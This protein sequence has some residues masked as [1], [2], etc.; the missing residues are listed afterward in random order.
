MFACDFLDALRSLRIGPRRA[1]HIA[2][3]LSLGFAFAEQGPALASGHGTDARR[4]LMAAMQ[5]TRYERR[6][7]DRAGRFSGR[8]ILEVGRV[9]DDPQEPGSVI[10]TM[11]VQSYDDEGRLKS[12]GQV[13]WRC[14][15]A[16][17]GMVMSL[18]IF[19]GEARK[20][21]VR[22]EAQGEPIMYPSTPRREEKLEDIAIDLKVKKGILP[23]L[24][25]R[26]A[27]LFANRRIQMIASPQNGKTPRQ[28]RITGDLVFKSYALGIRFNTKELRSEELIDERK[29]LIEQVL[30][31]EDGSSWIMKY[32]PSPKTDLRQ[33]ARAR[34]V[35]DDAWVTAPGVVQSG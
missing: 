2:V 17:L 1:A 35:D 4:T 12:K 33:S 24:G 14:A 30:R 5:G 20:L 13:E 32:I 7:Y 25:V 15:P 9:E 16:S 26:T 8:Q 28:Y 6:A 23:L 22:L 19:S 10:L 21:K 11:D 18:S 31:A 34:V 3:I 27:V 29:G